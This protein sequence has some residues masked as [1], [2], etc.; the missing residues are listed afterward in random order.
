MKKLIYFI[1]IVFIFTSCEDSFLDTAPN[2]AL[3]PSTFWKSKKDLD[4]ALTGCYSG[5]E[6]GNSILYRDAGS[7]NAF[8][9][10]PWEGWTNIGNGKLSPADPGASY[11]NFATINRCNEFLENADNAVEVPEEDRIIYKAQARFIRAY[12]YYVLTTNY[13]DVPLITE[14]FATPEEAKVPRNPQAEIRTFIENEL[15]A[16][17]DI[18]PESYSGSEFGKATK[19]AAQALLMR[20]YL[21]FKDYEQ[22][23]TTAK[24]ITGYSLHPSFKGLFDP[25]NEQNNEIILSVQHTPDIYAMSFTPFLPNSI[26]GWSSVVPTQ[27][28]VDAYGMVDGR[29]IQEAQSQGDY[30]PENPFINR[31]PRLRATVVYPGQIFAGR[32]YRSIEEDDPDYYNTADNASKT[33]Y[34]FK[35]YTTFIDIDPSA[36]FWNMGNDIFL[37]RYAEVLLTI[38]EA[39]IEL[40]Q[41]DNELYEAIDA[42]RLR[43]GMPAVDKQKYADQESLRKL[44]RN[45]R[46]VEFAMEGLRRDDIIRWDIASEVMN[47]ELLG[48]KKGSV[49]ETTQPNGDYNVSMTLPQNL[50]ET[51]EFQA[52]KNNLLPIPQS[53][54]DKNPKLTP[55]NTGY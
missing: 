29:T 39:K 9:N 48:A 36:P 34:N 1:G 50:I 37:F 8:N 52:P 5:F 44:I 22:A 15:T 55:N 25:T 19:G 7:D 3:S 2:D 51:R 4:L 47:G 46:R 30:D 40:G 18:L 53:A 20:N 42:V 54:I 14:N 41:I 27:S 33:G 16:V 6:S 23:L 17:I 13:G 26:G 45:E 28:L 31:D 10:F 32:V 21:Y 12:E 35:K 11:Y 24:S 49:L 43:A 38:A